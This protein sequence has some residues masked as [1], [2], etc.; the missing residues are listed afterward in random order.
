VKL[1]APISISSSSERCRPAPI[2]KGSPFLRNL[3]IS[4]PKVT[5]PPD[6]C[7]TAYSIYKGDIDVTSGPYLH[8][9]DGCTYCRAKGACP[10]LRRHINSE[11]LILL[12]DHPIQI[13]RVTDLTIQQKVNIFKVKTLLLSYLEEVELSL[14]QDFENSVDVP[15]L[16]IQAGKSVRKWTDDEDY[17]ANLLL[18]E[19]IEPYRRSL[20]TI[21]EAEKSLKKRKTRLPDDAFSLVQQRDK[22]VVKNKQHLDLLEDL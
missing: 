16:Q 12:E 7:K 5:P 22:I 4:S 21:T 3:T 18:A 6:A 8:V 9:N 11:A 14:F 19:G 10:E 13:P 20:I 17:V 2:P 15:E 1:S